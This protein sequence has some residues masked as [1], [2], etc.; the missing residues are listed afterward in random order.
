MTRV[1]RGRMKDRH[2][3]KVP[4]AATEEGATERG[5]WNQKEGIANH[6]LAAT[7]CRKGKEKVICVGQDQRRTWRCAV[8][9]SEKGLAEANLKIQKSCFPDLLDVETTKERLFSYPETASEG[10]GRRKER[11][12][13]SYAK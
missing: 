4:D 11:A 13:T 9:G 3:E 12:L 7:R 10:L 2:T 5:S 8:R 1:A 6:F